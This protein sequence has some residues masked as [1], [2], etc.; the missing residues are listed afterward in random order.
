MGKT[1]SII[2]CFDEDA[3]DEP[4]SGLNELFVAG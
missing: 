3:N 4:L 1:M 2:C